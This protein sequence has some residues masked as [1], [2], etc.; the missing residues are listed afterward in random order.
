MIREEVDELDKVLTAR[1]KKHVLSHWMS[2]GLSATYVHTMT[3]SP[4]IKQ[5]VVGQRDE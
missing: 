2:V 1:E 5:L 4:A 3:D